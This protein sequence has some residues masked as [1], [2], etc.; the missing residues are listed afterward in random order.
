[1]APANLARGIGITHRGELNGGIGFVQA[2]GTPTGCFAIFDDTFSGVA[3]PASALV[4][5]ERKDLASLPAC[6]VKALL[7]LAIRLSASWPQSLDSSPRA[8]YAAVER[9]AFCASR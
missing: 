7:A 8:R 5:P 2:L 3:S 4:A 6:S 9:R 1:M